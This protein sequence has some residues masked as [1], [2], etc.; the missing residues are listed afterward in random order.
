L[1]QR[2]GDDD[3]DAF[4]VHLLFTPVDGTSFLLT[5]D[6]TRTRN[7]AGNPLQ[8]IS[9]NPLSTPGSIQVPERSRS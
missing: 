1:G 6:Y 8:L 2:I 9:V 7:N 4:R 3:T 5:E